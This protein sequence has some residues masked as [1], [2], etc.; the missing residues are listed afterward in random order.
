MIFSVKKKKS[1]I[2]KNEFECY[3]CSVSGELKY[4]FEFVYKNKLKRN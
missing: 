1:V 3:G 4:F 2:M